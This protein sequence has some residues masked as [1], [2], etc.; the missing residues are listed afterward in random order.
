MDRKATK[1]SGEAGK[2][3]IQVV[4]RMMNL[5]DALATHEEAASLKNLAED[6]CVS[7]R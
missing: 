7:T 1:N 5:L 4:E 3:A 6:G 2:T